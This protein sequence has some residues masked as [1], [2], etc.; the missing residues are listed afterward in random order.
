MRQDELPKN[1]LIIS[2]MEFDSCAT[3]NGAY[4]RERPTMTLF[5]NI[6]SQYNTAGYQI[7]RLAFWNV[8][9]RTNV[10]PVKENDLGV[11]L[12]SGCSPNVTKMVMSYVLDRYECLLEAIIVERYQPIEERFKSL[13]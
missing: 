8:C 4:Y 10:I 1:I 9:S 7:P 3:V 11:A 5:D 12:V 2:D 13:I 6:A